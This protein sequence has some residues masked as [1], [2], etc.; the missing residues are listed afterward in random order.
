[1]GKLKFLCK[2]CQ[3]I[4]IK[5]IRKIEAHCV[6]SKLTHRGQNLKL[7][8]KSNIIYIQCV[9]PV[10]P[11]Y[12]PQ[13]ACRKILNP[14]RLTPLGIKISVYWTTLQIVQCT[15]FETYVSNKPNR[16]IFEDIYLGR[17]MWGIGAIF[18]LMIFHRRIHTSHGGHIETNLGCT[19]TTVSITKKNTKNEVTS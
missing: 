6:L 10:V 7:K 9:S 2:D 1:M 14:V 15:Q 5:K 3:K 18:G 19:V 11:T 8:T 17:W 16:D 12:L 13:I 4:K